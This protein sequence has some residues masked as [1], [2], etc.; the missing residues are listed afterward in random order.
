MTCPRRG[1]EQCYVCRQNVAAGGR[2]HFNGP[3]QC[4]L[5]ENEDAFHRSDVER[6]ERRARD[7]ISREH[8]DIRQ[9]DLAIQLSAAAQENENTRRSEA[10][11]TA[12]LY[13][14]RNPV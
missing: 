11:A 4:G 5:F 2:G 9:E 12:R 13:D 10:A 1:N 7:A 8:R 6:T 14:P 3:G